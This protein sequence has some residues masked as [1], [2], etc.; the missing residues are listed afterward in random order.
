RGVL[1]ALGLA[2]LLVFF[3][4]VVLF[5]L[6]FL[7]LFFFLFFFLFAHFFA[8]LLLFFA[9]PGAFGAFVRLTHFG[10]AFYVV[11]GIDVYVVL[12]GGIQ[13]LDESVTQELTDDVP[14][15]DIGIFKIAGKFRSGSELVFTV[16]FDDPGDGADEAFPDQLERMPFVILPVDHMQVFDDRLCIAGDLLVLGGGF[17]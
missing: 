11:D 10:V 15:V 14:G 7:L 3:F 6:F 4:F 8:G 13:G 1:S 12:E 9:G 17:G 5:L 16:I 2:L